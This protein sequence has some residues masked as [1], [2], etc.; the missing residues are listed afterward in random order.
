MESVIPRTD[1]ACGSAILAGSS[2]V[3][4]TLAIVLWAWP[5]AVS[6]HGP[7]A[8]GGLGLRFAGSWAAFLAVLA[9]LAAARPGR[10]EARVPVIALVLWPLAGLIAGVLHVDD[11]RAGAPRVAYLAGLFVLAGLAGT[12]AI[13]DRAMRVAF[14]RRGPRAMPRVAPGGRTWGTGSPCRGTS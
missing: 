7:F 1:I 6:N 2:L 3:Y 14:G 5:G 8:A 9:A 4:A 11:L 10:H 13:G 12:V